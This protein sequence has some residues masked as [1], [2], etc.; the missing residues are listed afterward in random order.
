MAGSRSRARTAS[1]RHAAGHRGRQVAPADADHLG[2]A[3]APP[4]EQAHRL[5]RAGAGG[6]HDPDATAAHDV[7]EAEAAASE[8]GR[9]CPGP[10]TSRPTSAA[11]SFSSISSSSDTLSLK[12]RTS[13][14]ARKALWA[15]SAANG[16]GTDT[17]ATLAPGSRAMAASRSRVGRRSVHRSGRRPLAPTARRRP[18]ASAASMIALVPL[19]RQQEV[20]GAQ[21]VQQRVGHPLIPHRVDVGRRRHE[22]GRRGRSRRRPAWPASPLSSSTESTYVSAWRRTPH[23]AA[24]AAVIDWRP[25]ARREGSSS[26]H[27]PSGTT[28]TTRWWPAGAPA[29]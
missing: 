1:A 15:S 9:P 26:P 28:G 10:M 3:L 22:R 16:P 11:C 21:L 8:R 4:V 29:W 24:C 19:H 6:G 27:R 18:T 20:A 17:M 25:A 2:D 7:G 14:P 13:R 12:S 5:L 23:D